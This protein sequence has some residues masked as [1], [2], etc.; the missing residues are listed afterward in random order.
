M[1]DGIE[2]C[3]K[4]VLVMREDLIDSS[5]E[6]VERI[7]VR[8]EHARDGQRA[9]GAERIEK[10]AQWIVPRVRIQP[11]IRGD[12]RQH[13]IAGEEHALGSVDEHGVIVRVPRRP[14]EANAPA[15]KVEILA[16]CGWRY[17]L[18]RVDGSPDLEPRRAHPFVDVAGHPVTL[19]PGVRLVDHRVIA[20]PHP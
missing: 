18:D 20:R 8:R 5:G 19:E 17:A 11:D 1:A 3:A 2:R 9:Y 14:L 15:T 6:I 16:V 7:S 13:M 4:P 12:S 10:I